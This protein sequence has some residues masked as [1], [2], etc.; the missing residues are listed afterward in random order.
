MKDD[1]IRAM[2][3]KCN[4][5]ISVMEKELGFKQGQLY[6]HC[7][8]MGLIAGGHKYRVLKISEQPETPQPPPPPP[9]KIDLNEGGTF[10]I[11]KKALN[12]RLVERRSGYFLDGQPVLLDQIMRAANRVRISADPP[13]QQITHCERWR[14]DQ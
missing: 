1:E 5:N 6:Y 13:L 3:R 11:A 8:N 7:K 9:K 10:S 2:H 12:E 14:I 4:G